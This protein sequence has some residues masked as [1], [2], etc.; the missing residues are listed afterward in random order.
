MIGV[1][2]TY[3]VIRV[4]AAEFEP[5][6]YAVAI[7][8]TDGGRVAARAD[9]DLSWIEID[10]AAVVEP[11]ERFGLRCR[12]AEPADV[13]AGVTVRQRVARSVQTAHGPSPRA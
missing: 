8:D 9:G 12:A 7:L 6:P 10:R 2:V 5:I 1:V 4:A 13:G 3:T 11:D